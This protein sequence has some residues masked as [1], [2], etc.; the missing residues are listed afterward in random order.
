MGREDTR[1]RLMR[2]YEARRTEDTI[3]ALQDKARM[4]EMERECTVTELLLVMIDREIAL[5]VEKDLRKEYSKGRNI[6]YMRRWFMEKLSTECDE[7]EE[8]VPDVSDQLRRKAPE[9]E[10]QLYFLLSQL[11]PMVPRSKEDMIS[12]NE[13][14]SSLRW[15]VKDSENKIVQA[16]LDLL[17]AVERQVGKLGRS[18]QKVEKRGQVDELLNQILGNIQLV[19]C[20]VDQS[21]CAEPDISSLGDRIQ[22][23]EAEQKEIES[24]IKALKTKD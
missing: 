1:R 13:F 5:D 23:C 3:E 19:A 10:A 11:I 2:R 17:D 16:I 21:G 24:K 12:Y 15:L 7:S 4:L 9:F 14:K 20:L 6:S 8:E 22:E 18:V